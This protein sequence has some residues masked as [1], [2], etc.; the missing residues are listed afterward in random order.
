LFLDETAEDCNR[1]IGTRLADLLTTI[2]ADAPALVT[3]TETA[4]RITELF[5]HVL[6]VG[7]VRGTLPPD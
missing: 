1:R 5:R 6:T 7:G 2:H 4:N 3:P